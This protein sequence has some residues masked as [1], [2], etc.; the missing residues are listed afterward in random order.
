MTSQEP[1]T[2]DRSPAL[3]SIGRDILA[4]LPGRV[5]P[6]I[7]AFVTTA[8]LTKYVLTPADFGRYY[9]AMRVVLFLTMA[10][11]IWM[12]TVL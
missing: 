3:T 11:V 1:A 8:V 7:M 4:Y 5:V 2:L 12:T 10:G 9:L 6:A